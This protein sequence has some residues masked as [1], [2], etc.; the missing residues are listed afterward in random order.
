MITRWNPP[1]VYEIQVRPLNS[2]TW[3]TFDTASSIPR[4]KDAVLGAEGV[5]RLSQGDLVRAWSPLPKVTLCL[6][7]MSAQR[8]LVEAGKRPL[9][10]KKG[11]G[12]Q[13]DGWLPLWEGPH[14]DALVIAAGGEGGDPRRQALAAVDCTR[15]VLREL[16]TRMPSNDGRVSD[17]LNAVEGW[18]RGPVSL[19]MVQKYQDI[20]A[21]A[22]LEYQLRVDEIYQRSVRYGYPLYRETIA[23]FLSAEAAQHAAYVALM[24]RGN[25]CTTAVNYA[26]QALAAMRVSGAYSAASAMPM[27]DGQTEE[28]LVTTWHTRQELAPA[29]RRWIP[30]PVA[31]LLRLGESVPLDLPRQNP[32]RRRDKR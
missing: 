7:V 27:A 24:P 9:E 22:A 5:V 2:D 15:Q 25:N 8:G 30:L 18:A 1:S 21:D 11:Q 4:A 16:F 32:G 3:R 10:I 14:A 6:A 23:L 19:A 28:F 29:A 20:C 31:L 26:A 12:R 17:T 13:S